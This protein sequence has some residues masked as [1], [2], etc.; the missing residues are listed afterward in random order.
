MYVSGNATNHYRMS[1]LRNALIISIEEEN[2][3]SSKQ[4]YNYC[5]KTRCSKSDG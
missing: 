1:L 4:K 5:T 2:G 3:L